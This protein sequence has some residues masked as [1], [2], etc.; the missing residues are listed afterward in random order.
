MPVVASFIDDLLSMRQEKVDKRSFDVL[1][2][3]PTDANASYNAS[4]NEYTRL[5]ETC[6][7][8]NITTRKQLDRLKTPWLTKGLR[9]SIKHKNRLYKAFI[10][11]PSAIRK[12]KYKKFRNKLTH[13]IRRAKRT[14][15][16]GE[17]ERAKDDLK[18]T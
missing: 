13:L 2:F 15:Y 10:K 12:S 3:F 6:F 18:S 9:K 8:L 1:S 11:S 16:D 5:F 7:P 17:F 14:H 4:T